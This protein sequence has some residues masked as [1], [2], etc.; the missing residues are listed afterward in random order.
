MLF[1]E[2]N[3]NS[4]SIKSKFK[5]VFWSIFLSEFSFRDIQ[6]YQDP[7]SVRYVIISNKVAVIK[8]F[9]AS[10]NP[11]L[12]SIELI[13]END[14]KLSCLIRYVICQGVYK[15]E[16]MWYWE[17]KIFFRSCPSKVSGAR[18]KIDFFWKPF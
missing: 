15:F 17:R 11:F 7:T 5:I 4:S 6:L 3:C 1:S 8:L 18:R 13:S 12:H 2:G 14:K 10:W 16:H 9:S